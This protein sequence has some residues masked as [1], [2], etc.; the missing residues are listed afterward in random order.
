MLLLPLVLG[1]AAC[2]PGAP[3]GAPDEAGAAAAAPE[4]AAAT[5]AE[6]P[7][8]L[9]R[10]PRGT[11]EAVALE[12]G[13]SLDA[14]GRVAAP[15]ERVR[16]RDTVHLSLVTVGEAPAAML[17]VYWR[18]AGGA[19]IEADERAIQPAGPAVH[20]FSRRVEAGWP[21]GRYEVEVKL[22]GESA[23]VRSFEVR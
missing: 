6:A 8:E 23:G 20:T 18:E 13:A 21:A 16:P 3:G 7:P 19:V 17:S 10:L 12:L 4:A 15:V 2:G 5:A 14:D 9:A 22:N 11:L 1:L